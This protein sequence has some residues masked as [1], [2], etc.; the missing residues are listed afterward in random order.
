M[1]VHVRS[2]RFDISAISEHTHAISPSNCSRAIYIRAIAANILAVNT[3]IHATS[4]DGK[5]IATGRCAIAIN[6]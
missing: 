5:E 3:D 6:N 2:S 4:F 1:L